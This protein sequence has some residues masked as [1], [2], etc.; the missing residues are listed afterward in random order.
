T[1]AAPHPTTH[2]AE[3]HTEAWE[4]ATALHES[5]PPAGAT[6]VRAPRRPPR[7]YAAP[8]GGADTRATGGAR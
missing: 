1:V 2:L 7:V 4:M 5:R 3:T 8:F 6:E